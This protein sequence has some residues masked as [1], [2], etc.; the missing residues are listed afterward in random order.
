M[1]ARK[2][3]RAARG[4]AELLEWSSLLGAV[5]AAALAAHAR[6]GLR[7]ATARL[8]AA[9]RSGSM[10]RW[11]LLHGEPPLYAITSAGLRAI[12]AEGIAPVR[13]G[14]ATARHA[15]ACC[16]AAVALEAAFDGRRV[17]GEP[18]IRREE[19]RLGAPF[20]R[21]PRGGQTHRP[22]LLIDAHSADR[23]PVA[24]ELEL[25]VKAPRRL[26]AICRAWARSRRVEG[27]IY[28]V[29]PGVAGPV[30]RALAAAHAQERIAVLELTAIAGSHAPRP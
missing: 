8:A 1:T 11:Q 12:D 15:A 10:R 18:A 28:L 29:G 14:P 13:L 9:E 24:V 3:A 19:R 27:V 7:S 2:P 16:A 23:R 6:I 26:H 17:L 5:D 22:D 21:L 25:T 4:R 20:A 30:Q